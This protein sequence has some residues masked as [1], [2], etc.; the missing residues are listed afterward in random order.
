MRLGAPLYWFVFWVVNAGLM[1]AVVPDRQTASRLEAAEIDPLEEGFRSVP[2]SAKPWVYYWWLNGNV[3]EPTIL[4]DLEAMK[5]LGVGG[6]L[7]FDARGYWDDPTHVVLPPSRMEFMSPQWRKMLRF[8]LE[9]AH[10]LGL[11]VSVN[12][13]SCAGSLK[14]PWERGAD[15]PKKLLY[16]VRELEGPQKL[17]YSWQ[18]PESGHFW[19]IATLGVLVGR[20]SDPKAPVEPGVRKPGPWQEPIRRLALRV[21]DLTSQVDSQGR[22]VWDVEAGHWVLLRFA[23]TTMEGRQYDVDILDAEA[24]RGHFDRMGKT[25]IEDA[26]GLVGKSLTHFYSVSWE[27]ALP[28]WTRGFDT[29]FETRRGYRIRPWLPVLAGFIVRSREESDRFLRDYHKTLAE[30]F[31]D[32]YY[33]KLQELCQQHGL[34]WHAESG[35]PWDRNLPVFTEADQLAFLGRTDMPQGEFWWGGDQP[36]R[37]RG[38]NRCAAIS[39]RIYG[40]PLAAAEAFTHMVLHWSAYPAALKPRADAAF[41]E[42]INHLI[43]HTFTASPSEFGKPGIE[44]FAGTHLNPNVTWFHAAGAFLSYLGRCQWLLRQGHHVADVCVYTSDRPYLTWSSPTQKWDQSVMWSDRATLELPPGYA[45]DLLNTEVLLDRLTCRQGELLLPEG[46]RYRM[47]ILDPEDH[48]LEV[49]V[50]EKL[51]ELAKAGAT[52]I[53]GRRQPERTPGLTG[54]PACDQKVRELYNRLTQ[55]SVRGIELEELFRQ[56]GPLP[57]FEGPWPYVHR[58][59]AEVDLYFIS[60]QGRARCV[61][62]VAGKKPEFWDPMTGA[63]G[64]PIEWH[65]TEDG[66]TAVVLELPQNGSIFVVF[67]HPSESSPPVRSSPVLAET[68]PITG[69]WQVSF[70][71]DWGPKQPIVFE[72]LIP[73]NEHADEEIRYFSG[74]AIYRKSFELSSQQA[75]RVACL[76]LGQV[77]HVAEVR[78]NGKNLGIIWT[79]PWR[80]EV[81]GALREGTNEL[82]IAVTNTWVNRLIGDAGLPPERRRT[83][84]NVALRPGKRS[85]DFRLFQGF[86][87]ED[88]LV[89]SGLLGPVK[90]EFFEGS[91]R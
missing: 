10:R 9:N 90:L 63:I 57:D 37:H 8:T 61:F 78:L 1:V 26:G 66:R 46:K 28:T 69:P 91:E 75:S 50:L 14:G 55:H 82:E 70:D 7:L 65:P 64:D 62:R 53:L 44:Y 16:E 58:Q 25:I 38:F 45:Y 4:R 71:P 22:L 18:R 33:G 48:T 74:T 47:L 84:T 89:T 83:Q 20:V 87:S 59:T 36:A 68:V 19:E 30:C 17:V 51:V 88:P 72:S 49:A 2:N 40:R 21:V 11:E 13:S 35:G 3:D 56:R 6:I 67:R 12:L 27:G 43:W 42:G 29:H 31:C 32:H 23:Y 24:V 79:T 80:V 86:A 60:G 15:V 41:C 34:K 85:A 39:A 54:F 81:T 76:Q 5:Q 52:I 77:C 73:W